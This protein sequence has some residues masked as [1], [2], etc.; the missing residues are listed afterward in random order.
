MSPFAGHRRAT[1][2]F[3][4]NV[5]RL[6]TLRTIDLLSNASFALDARRSLFD[7]R[8]NPEAMVLRHDADTAT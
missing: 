4:I 6:G 5:E 1:F 7:R 3:A 2:Q 8:F